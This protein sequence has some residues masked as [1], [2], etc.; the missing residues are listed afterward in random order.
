MK[1][2]IPKKLILGILFSVLIAG[3]I[4]VF[5]E[6][7][8]AQMG[9]NPVGPAI[10]G[11]FDAI[12]DQ[13]KDQ[14][15]TDAE[16]NAAAAKSVSSSQTSTSEM[17]IPFLFTA[18]GGILWLIMKLQSGLIQFSGYLVDTALTIG[19]FTH[20]SIVQIGWS[21][22]RDLCN[23]AFAIIL[24]FMAF[25]TV[26][27]VGNV[28][29]KLLPKLIGVALL[30]NFSLVFAGIIIDFSQILTH[31]FVEAA[32]GDK[33]MS[34]QLM[35]ALQIARIYDTSD[36]QA[37][38]NIFQ[39][40]INIALGPTLLMITEQLF[41]VI[42]FAIATFLFLIFALLLV[43]R[44]VI[45][46]IQLIF[47]PLAL[48][49]LIVKIPGGEM[50][51]WG[52]WKDEF[53]KWVFFA[54]V[55][56][57]FIYLALTIA[58]NKTFEGLTKANPYKE[59]IQG[60]MASGFYKEPWIIFQYI[61]IVMIMLA[62]LEPAKKLGG[63]AGKLTGWANKKVKDW[64]KRPG[65]FAYDKYAPGIT[66]T[67]GAA[68]AGIGLT[69]FGN[70]MQSKAVQ[71]QEK[72][73]DR[74]QHK[75]YRASI[76]NM[77][78]EAMAYE[79][80]HAMGVRKLIAAEEIKARG[81]KKL[82][83]ED[84]RAAM[85][86]FQGFNRRKDLEEA[87]ELRPEVIQDEE[88]QK[89]AIQR[90]I[91]GSKIS[92][93][94]LGAYASLNPNNK[95]LVA[96]DANSNPIPN[97]PGANQT[98]TLGA[99]ALRQVI[100]NLGDTDFSDV[101]KGLPRQMKLAWEASM[102]E[103]VKNPNST[104]PAAELE[105]IRKNFANNV[106]KIRQAFTNANGSV[107][108]AAAKAHAQAM[109]PEVMANVKSPI[110]LDFIG[111]NILLSQLQAIRGELN[112]LQKETIMQGI[113]HSGDQA[114]IDFIS[115]DQFWAGSRKKQRGGGRGQRGAQNPPPPPGGTTGGQQQNQPGG[116]APPGG[117]PNPPGTP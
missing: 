67:A 62:G 66:K 54:P 49:S 92:Q 110:D 13:A 82:S 60:V 12:K 38:N 100:K 45:I 115:N 93:W 83:V 8:K 99:E 107:D 43:G 117:Q 31:Y 90:A 78:P 19:S 73:E 96:T 84:A 114:N 97:Q 51:S 39:K 111:Q 27:Q 24:L 85:D 36:L 33:G 81:M 87:E 106:G 48:V 58:Q 21:I 86:T 57:F 7:A 40:A 112:G 76:K 22:T 35:N 63:H 4:F 105:N 14:G 2:R 30:I 34:S 28:N 108:E 6:N 74:S 101:F 50:L 44:I 37:N 94:A 32:S 95:N 104:I 15:A 11:Q 5:A 116:G 55:Y 10:Q 113:K 18:I 41:A 3:G 98:F 9:A 64:S 69:R 91:E 77:S 68:L 16:A 20:A 102:M 71:I 46:W 52:K 88:R 61:A 89:K 26:L 80:N 70:R 65:Q 79:M 53:F 1:N 42:L 23:L 72:A 75:A 59:N 109:S 17:R 103:L 47:L 29:H 56:T 25:G